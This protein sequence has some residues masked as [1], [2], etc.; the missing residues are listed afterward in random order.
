M[1]YTITTTGPTI[2]QVMKNFET[3]ARASSEAGMAIGMTVKDAVLN[4]IVS[5]TKRDSDGSPKL[6]TSIDIETFSDGMVKGWGVGN[7]ETMNSIASDDSGRSYWLSINAGSYIP[8][9]Q[10]GSFSNDPRKPTGGFSGD[11]FKTGEGKFLIKP[12]KTV[13]GMHFI[14]EGQIIM[15][16]FFDALVVI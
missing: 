16:T 1:S 6:S 5:S 9:K 12:N 11:R 13:E 2:S 4:K 3:K 8:P 7:I 10:I 15:D 14:E